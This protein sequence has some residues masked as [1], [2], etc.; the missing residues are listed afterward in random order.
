MKL[1]DIKSKLS[2]F[3]SKI[4]S[5]SIILVGTTLLGKVIGFVK[6]HFMARIF[7]V[8]QELDVFR[9]AFALPDLVFALLVIGTVNAALVPIFIK[10]IRKNEQKELHTTLNTVIT[11]LF[12]AMF[13]ILAVIYFAMPWIAHYL[14]SSKEVMRA[15]NI[16]LVLSKGSAEYYEALFINLSRLMLLS[17]LLL[18]VSSVFGA[19]LQAHKRFI[20][21]ALAP[22][23]YNIGIVIGIIG[24]VKFA[25]EFGIYALSYSVLLGTV[26]HFV[27]QLIGI[28]NLHDNDYSW[29]FKINNYVKEIGKLS[30]PR[31]FGL[32]VEQIAIMFNTF[33]SFTLGAGALSVYWFASSLHSVPVDILS[34]SFLQAIFPHLNDK[35]NE[36]DNYESLNKLYWKALLLLCFVAIPIMILFIVLRLPIVRLIFGAGQFTWTAT[37]VT[38]FTLVFFTPAILLQAMA[39]LNIR[40]FYAIHNTRTPLIVSFVGVTL[41]ILFSIGFTNFFSHYHDILAIL[42][43]PELWLSSIPTLFSWFFARNGS[44]AAVAG[45]AFGISAG[46]FIEVAVSFFL[47][48]KKIGLLAYGLRNKLFASLRLLALASIVTFAG[49]YALYRFMDYTM[50]TTKT[51]SV[52]ILATV[53]A[54]GSGLLYLVITKS[55]WEQFMTLE[56]ILEKTGIKRLFA[57]N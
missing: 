51:I 35:A 29:S 46:L 17:P 4:G 10:M 22:V 16:S 34:G 11:I 24:F 49:S 54:L 52:L 53:T 45:L 37:I 41:N 13:A 47:L 3:E 44:F 1:S 12:V 56:K 55:V 39:A 43:A 50:D 8:S 23:M 21:T 27:T 20:T 57:K 38:S 31:I 33:W 7:G 48:S 42:K 32:G 36:N 30:L 40:T 14:F 6:L 15:V 9:A 18:A 26:L 2:I 28:F 19:Y 25:P 5:A